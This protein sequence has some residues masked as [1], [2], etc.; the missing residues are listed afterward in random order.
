MDCSSRLQP[1]LYF[2]VL[3]M[4]SFTKI[5]EVVGCPGV[6]ARSA[7][8]W[9]CN[10]QTVMY[11]W[12][13]PALHR[14]KLGQTIIIT[15]GSSTASASCRM[16]VAYI[17]LEPGRV[18]LQLGW[19]ARKPGVVRR[20]FFRWRC[21]CKPAGCVTSSSTLSQCSFGEPKLQRDSRVVINW[22]HAAA[23]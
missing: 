6:A 1:S 22:P 19:Q 12:S 15:A 20:L 17:T 8:T 11:M 4:L 3:A 18:M 23:S 5:Q 16:A 13:R 9:K 14:V 21:E 2:Q 7:A 10:C